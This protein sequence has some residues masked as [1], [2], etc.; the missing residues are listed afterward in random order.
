MQMLPTGEAGQGRFAP[1]PTGR[2]G[3]PSAQAGAHAG[4]APPDPCPGPAGHPAPSAAL[5]GP[6]PLQL[7]AEACLR[8][9]QRGQWGWGG[10]ELTS[11][12]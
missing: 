8:G 10:G 4:P 2:R 6:C 11:L 5:P 9:A 1:G 3:S 12:Q 7:Q